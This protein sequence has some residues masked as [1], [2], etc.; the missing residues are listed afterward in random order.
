MPT[1]DAEYYGDLIARLLATGDYDWARD[2]LEGIARTI[3]RSGE[4]TLRQRSAIDHVML[5]R[6]RHDTGR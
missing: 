3:V 6:L 2:T 5:G 1:R 4:V